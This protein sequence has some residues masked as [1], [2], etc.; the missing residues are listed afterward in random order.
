MRRLTMSASVGA[1]LLFLALAGPALAASG[2]GE[3]VGKNLGE[4]LGGWS[5]SLYAGIAGLV[6]LVFLFNR[7]FADLAI[8]MVAA[9]L[10][11]GFVMAP[12]DIASTVRDIWH[13]VAG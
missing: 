11:G 5:K 12:N 1:T 3:R 13:T 8:F 9:V 4:L 7:R 2:D 10:V 6:A